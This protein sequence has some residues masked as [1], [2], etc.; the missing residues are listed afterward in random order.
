MAA[1]NGLRRLRYAAVS[2]NIFGL[3]LTV[4]TWAYQVW[5]RTP[6]PTRAYPTSFT[7]GAVCWLFGLIMFIITWIVEGS[8]RRTQR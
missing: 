8:E 1:R 3:L 7:L 5:L 2:I 4:G 6:P